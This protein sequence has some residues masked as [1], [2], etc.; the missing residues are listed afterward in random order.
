MGE[1]A[2]ADYINGY[3]SWADSNG[4]SYLAW[5][6]NADFNSCSGP[7]VNMMGNW[8]GTAPSSPFGTDFYNH[9]KWVGP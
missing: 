9:L 8:T 1:P 5:A 2:G 3:M 6:W 4:V 7:S